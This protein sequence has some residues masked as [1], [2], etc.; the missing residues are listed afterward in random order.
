MKSIQLSSFL[1]EKSRHLSQHA[2]RVLRVLNLEDQFEGIVYCDYA[3]E[4][5]VCKPEEEF[6]HRVSTK[7][8]EITQAQLIVPVGFEDSKND[9]SQ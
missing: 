8:P 1:A 5:F 3:E 4:N 6:Y 2:S 9:R 7:H